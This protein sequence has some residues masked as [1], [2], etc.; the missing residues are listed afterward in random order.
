LTS[1]VLKAGTWASRRWRLIIVARS[2]TVVAIRLAAL[3][4]GLA[5][6]ALAATALTIWVRVRAGI[7]SRKAKL[8]LDLFH[9]TTVILIR[10]VGWR[11]RR[12]CCSAGLV[13]IGSI[14]IA[15]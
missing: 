9:A 2:L 7:L 3:T 8:P 6:L 13:I 10:I 1:V 11:W 5:D 15:V 14:G 12:M 4:L